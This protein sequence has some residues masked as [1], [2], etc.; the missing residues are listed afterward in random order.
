M[1]CVDPVVAGLEMMEKEA[2]G[3]EAQEKPLPKTLPNRQEEP[4]YVGK[5]VTP[6]W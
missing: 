4:W 5:Y 6:M 3:D 1:D 2:E